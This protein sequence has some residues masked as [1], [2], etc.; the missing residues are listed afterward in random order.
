MKKMKLILLLMGIHLML[1]Q[2]CSKNSEV[3]LAT[4]VLEIDQS[5]LEIGF[6]A[7]ESSSN[8]QVN[9]NAENLQIESS[10]S[11]CMTS[12]NS[13]SKNLSI[14]VDENAALA[15]RSTTI[16]LT[17]GNLSQTISVMQFGIEPSIFVSIDT[18]MT[19]FRSKDLT[20]ELYSNVGVKAESEVDWM[21]NTTQLKSV[22][23]N[24]V[25]YTF[26]FNIKNLSDSDVREGHLY[27]SH[28]EGDLADTVFVKQLIVVSDDYEPGSSDVFE[29]DQKLPVL[30]ATLTPSDKF[31]GGQ[32][33]DMSLDGELGTLYHSPWGGM[34]DKPAITFEYMLDPEQSSVMNY[35]VLHPRISGANG[36]IKTATVWVKTQEKPTYEK[37]ADIAAANSNNPVVV[38]FETPVLNPRGVKIIVTD[39]YTHDAGKYYVSLAEFECYESKSLNALD[40]DLKFFTD[41]T[42]SELAPGIG[43]NDLAQIKNQFLQNIAAYLLTGKYPKEFRVQEYEPYRPFGELAS[44]LK[45]SAYSQFE[46]P[47]GIYFSAEEEV[48][49][50]VGE[51]QGADMQLRVKDFG[52]SGDDNSY[53]LKEGLN[54]L[55]MKGQGN[56]Y[57]SYY[58]NDYESLPKVKVHIAS[59]QVN[60]YFDI[61]RHSNED[62]RTLLEQA[63][64]GIMDIKGERVQLAYSV[65][66]LKNYSLNSLHELTTIYDS[67]VSS[68]QT[69]MGLRKYNRLPKNHM[70]GRV[71]WEGYMHADGW[72]AAFHDNTMS[73]IADPQKL[74]NS[75]WGP[76]HEFGHVNQ[77]RPGL[78]WV[79]TTEVTN[80]IFSK[81]SQFNYT[82]YSMRLEHENVGGMVGGR[83][84][85][86]MN[87]AFINQQE[88]GLQ[89]G[90]DANYGP[91]A[92]NIWGGDVFVSLVPLWQLQ[93]FF[94]IAG[95][96]N[97]WHRP[98]FYADV[99]EAVRNTN[100]SGMPHGQLQLN[101]VKNV[102]DAVQ[103]DLTD[104]FTQIGML[105]PVDKMFNDYTNRQKTITQSMVDETVSYISQYP[106]PELNHSIQ[107][108]SVNS[109]QAY[110]NRLPV[111]GT[112]G[113]GVVALSNQVKVD[114]AA[115]RNV[116]IFETF[117]GDELSWIT[118]VGTGD[119]NNRS[120]LVAYPAGATRIEAVAFDGA[121]T[122]VYGE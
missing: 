102:C 9:T 90:P 6:L 51:K 54:V 116:T 48:I 75:N 85:A 35:L 49:L 7:Q 45:T 117:S 64:S 82:P 22:S 12:Y 50:F 17:H 94:H 28:E 61:S 20:I 44:E 118:M 4:P 71:I 34:P 92:N 36:I 93:L 62:G 100:E 46:N 107:Y 111:V 5:K 18:L 114:H 77:T 21:E 95:E 74:R 29:K 109:Y 66:S 43:I 87:N 99:F 122:L 47:T 120:T 86:Y 58:S 115:W 56:G 53:P 1:L 121:R 41:A 24:P 65:N 76:A 81:W 98:Y 83:F 70:L 40:Q 112:Y 97:E 84:N 10:A 101:F 63:V 32:N 91:N 79:G 14:S 103:Y 108:I 60:G 67:I 55:S 30:S 19:D 8:I 26:T 25:K 96:G 88:W 104:F 23:I 15:S 16:K 110:K 11:W 80:N 37:V 3:T 73:T 105:T 39:A 59:G 89:A 119:A 2:S 78:V 33:I 113:E 27:F 106:K 38:S 52:P 42:F 72:G 13:Q 68:Q 57:I 69:M 31:Q